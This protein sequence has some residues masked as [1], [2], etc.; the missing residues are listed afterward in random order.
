VRYN[1]NTA[2][3]AFPIILSSDKRSETTVNKRSTRALLILGV[4]AL[5]G[6]G[7]RENPAAPRDDHFDGAQLTRGKAVFEQNCARCHG[8]DAQGAFGWQNQQPDGS[9]LPPPLNG[10]GHAWHHPRAALI[11]VIETGTRAQGGT[12][13]AW[14]GKLTDAQIGDVVTWIESLWPKQ[15]YEEWWHMNQRYSDRQD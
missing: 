14:S 2:L 6:C 10:T 7:H 8:A 12:M 5:A 13:P 9:Y 3:T 15:T 1:P 11:N 4:L